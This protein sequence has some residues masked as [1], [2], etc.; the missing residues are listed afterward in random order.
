MKTRVAIFSS[1]GLGDGL[2]QL[3]MANNFHINGYEVSYY[4]DFVSQ[5]QD[6]IT[7]ILV[8]PF[9][10]YDRLMQELED[11]QI[12]LYDSTSYFIH[13]MPEPLKQW[14]S[15]N[16]ICYS[17]SRSKPRHQTINV[18]LLKRRCPTESDEF[19]HRLIG[20]NRSFRSNQ[21]FQ[22]RPSAVQLIA[23]AMQQSLGFKLNT[24]ENG[25]CISDSEL[26]ANLKRIV[27]HPTSSNTQKNWKQEQFID[28]ADQLTQQG[29]QAVFTVSP[30]E[31]EHWIDLVAG[32][33]E[34]PLFNTIKQ[35]AQYYHT[36]FAFIGND[37]G[38]AHLASC[39]GLPNLVIFNRWR[40]SP[41]WRPA[42]GISR[43]VYPRT[44]SSKNWQQKI[45]V[46]R[47]LDSFNRMI[48]ESKHGQNR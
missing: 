23:N 8:Q 25:V 46:V 44:L 6:Y 16:G 37:S 48:K 15:E 45:P 3:V 18:E 1:H 29:W 33:Y 17:L 2:I 38:N 47:V 27:I 28:L 21:L 10:D 26:S 39:L 30:K 42:W 11:I 35:L 12:I 31:R 22:T 19:L 32:K 13:Q 9:P 4:N 24:L 14:L 34:V 20:L 36:S 43:I 40:K 7:G 5:L 41:T